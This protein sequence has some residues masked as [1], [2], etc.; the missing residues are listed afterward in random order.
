LIDSLQ[1]LWIEANVEVLQEWGTHIL[2]DLGN[3]NVI[4]PPRLALVMMEARDS[5]QQERFCVGE[6]LVTEC[7]V[8]VGEELFRGRVMGNQPLRAL[9]LALLTAALTCAPETLR[10]LEAFFD[11]EREAIQK[12]RDRMSRAL[13]STKVQFDTMTP[14]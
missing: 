6:L 11:R 3:V 7:Q 5:V 13:A 14:T 8:T 12:R 1:E 9:A 2:N 4:S 10:N